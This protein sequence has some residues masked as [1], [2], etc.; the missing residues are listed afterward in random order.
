MNKFKTI[1]KN[2]GVIILSIIVFVPGSLVQNTILTIFNFQN[3]ACIISCILRITITVLLAWLVSAKVLKIDD[4]TLGLKLKPIKL[5]LIILAILLPLLILLFYA[6]ILP[7]KP[8][9]TKEGKL[10]NSLINGIFNTGLPAGIC[11]EL[12]FRGMIFRYMKKTLGQ[13]AA[14]IIPAVLFACLHILNM[15][16]F[17]LLDLILLI[18]AGS[19]VA[20]MFTFFA[21]NSDSIWPGALAHSLWNFLIIGNLFGIGEIVNGK[22]N[23][24]YIIIPVKSAGKLLTGGNF[25]VEAA[26]PSII[27]YILVSICIYLIGKNKKE[28]I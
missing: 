10:L 4:E 27:G 18:L 24:S 23:A 7:G 6:Y 3:L 12:I 9:V 22:P 1:L 8:Y 20:V 13:K 15:Q 28:I 26:L 11:E 19:S 16:T 2:I 14:V 5:P 17:N 21:L 25:G